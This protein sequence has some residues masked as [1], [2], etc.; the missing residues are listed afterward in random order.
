MARIAVCVGLLALIV[1][2]AVAQPAAEQQQDDLDRMAAEQK[3]QER[4]TFF[5]EMGLPR[6]AATA[7]AIFAETGMDPAQMALM[8][9]IGQQGG[10]QAMLPMLMMNSM[11]GAAPLAPAMVEREGRLFIAEGGMLYVIDEETLEVVSTIEYAPKPPPEDSP[12]WSLLGPMITGARGKAQQAACMSNLKQLGLAFMMYLEDHDGWLPDGNWVE[13]T[14]PYIKNRQVYTCPSRPDQPV[15]YALNEALL[16]QRVLDIENPAQ[17][18][19]AFETLEPGEAPVG[20]AELVPPDGIHEGSIN[21]LFA[22]GHVQTVTAA[23]A[24]QLLQGQ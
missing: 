23:Q 9:M 13:V 20:G 24:R 12:I 4:I 10:E 18:V 16:A 17:T 19:L 2:P 11:R 15:G 8:I 14:Y 1:L 7:M 5:E 3:L 6:D 22:D 21:V